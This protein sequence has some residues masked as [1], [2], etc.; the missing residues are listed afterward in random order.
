MCGRFTLR[1]PAHQL[2]E[3][4][5]LTGVPD[6]PLRYNIAPSQPVPA[7]RTGTEG[8]RELVFLHWGLVPS[9]SK[10]RTSS[11]HMINA[12]AETVPDKPS[13]RAAW[14]RRRCL[15]LADGYYEWKKGGPHK[16]PYWIHLRGG[17]PFGFG[18][19]WE[20]WT[21]P[22]SPDGTPLQSC[23]IIT[24][25]ANESTREIHDRM[26]VIVPAE[27][28]PQWL[29]LTPLPEDLREV[30]LRPYPAD[31]I[32]ADPVSTYVNNPRHEGPECLAF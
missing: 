10:D 19:L 26:P 3:P 11:S 15:V 16:Q 24:T 14:K 1:T 6:I 8:E 13:F 21:D 18:G 31:E 7:V 29:A 17:Q 4:F 23:T 27:L 22:A 32:V 5:G 28:Y 25:Q 30:V 12:R 9:W 20:S 2:V